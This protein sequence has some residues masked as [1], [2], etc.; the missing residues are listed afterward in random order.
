ML[1]PGSSQH[2][3]AS[4][5]TCVI[6]QFSNRGNVWSKYGLSSFLIEMFYYLVVFLSQG[7]SEAAT[8]GAL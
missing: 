8:G 5:K 2:N 4:A 7:V 3:E 1:K 6:W